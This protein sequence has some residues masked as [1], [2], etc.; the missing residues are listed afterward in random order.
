MGSPD[1]IREQIF[2]LR[3][4]NLSYSRIAAELGITKSKVQRELK[5]RAQ[6]GAT[7]TAE[8]IPAWAPAANGGG[9]PAAPA[10]DPYA[11]M[12]PELVIRRRSL[13]S[14][15][16]S[17]AELEL[18]ARE[19]DTRA[20][21][22]LTR[23]AQASGD[24]QSY[25]T[26]VLQELNRL[27]DRI[28][29]RERMI[30]GAGGAPRS[31]ARTVIDALSEFREMGNVVSS[32]APPRAPTS[33]LDLE[34]DLARQ[35]VQEESQRIMR[36]DQA[37]AERERLK[38]EG[39]SARNHAIAK[40]IEESGPAFLEAAAKWFQQQTSRGTAAPAVVPLPSSSSSETVAAAATSSNGAAAA[41]AAASFGAGGVK[42][43]CPRCGAGEM[44]IIPTGTDDDRCPACGLILAVSN[45]QIVSGERTILA[46]EPARFAS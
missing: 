17:L 43:Y 40:V 4:Q 28:E 30:D 46:I 1:P 8:P 21:L 45:G 7:V 15:R 24:P 44:E 34:F 3:G 18:E 6:A 19:A 33:A 5:A 35:R 36:K 13:E 14:R 11:G 16:L 38:I 12:D 2:A 41:P 42:G 10:A 25:A 32:F 37:E 26:L 29:A 31:G 27:R 20:R 23:A 39:E 9:R 22:Q